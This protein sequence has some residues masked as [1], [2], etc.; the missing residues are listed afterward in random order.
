MVVL[1]AAAISAGAY[2][3]FRGGQA[4]VKKT[5]ERIKDATRERRRG[6]ECDELEEKKKS[7]QERIAAIQNLRSSFKPGSKS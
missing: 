2:G 3:V 4:A 7:R 1:A 5:S 6:K